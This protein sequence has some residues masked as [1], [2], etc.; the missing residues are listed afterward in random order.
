MILSFL[1]RERGAADSYTVIRVLA[2]LK[3][4]GHV[5]DKLI[6]KC[7]QESLIKELAEKI[8]A[9]RPGPTLQG[10]PP[11][12]SSGSNGVTERGIKEAEYQIRSMMSPLDDRLGTNLGISSDVLPWVIELGAVLVNRYLVGHDGKTAYERMKGKESKMLGFEFGERVNFRRIP[13]CRT[14]GEIGKSIEDRNLRRLPQHH[15]RVH[16]CERGW[17]VQDTEHQESPGGGKMEQG[18]GPSG[19]RSQAGD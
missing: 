10:H 9:E 17:R 16:G 14:F 13:D 3:E 4:I 7:D 19:G 5:G 15:W 2:F 12:W 8:A 11:L 18:G 6:V 1:V